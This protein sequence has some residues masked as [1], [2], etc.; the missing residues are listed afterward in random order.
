V[1]VEKREEG[2]SMRAA[3]VQFAPVFGEVELN[4]TRAL[5][6]ISD[7]DADLFVFPELAL[8]GYVFA[9]RAEA[10]ELAQAPDGPELRRVA[11]AAAAK[12]ACVVIGFAER[13]GSSVFNS[14]FFAAPDGA[15]AV[16]RKIHLFDREKTLFDPGDG[17]PLVVEASG[18]RLGLMVCFDWI[19]PEAARTLA[20]AGADVLCHS[21]NLVLPYCQNAVHREPRVRRHGEQDRDRDPCRRVAHLHRAQPDRLAARR[22][23]RAGERGPRGG[24]RGRGGSGGRAGQA[25][26]SRERPLPGQA[27][28]PLQAGL[29]R[30]Q[31]AGMLLAESG[32]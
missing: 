7:Q 21:A 13:A 30:R 27:S 24:H 18:A 25:R 28:Q 16:Y 11:E 8:S 22:R 10:L 15:R 19:F 1:T 32:S 14:S 20:L 6:F 29:V 23:A 31:T 2:T 12:R 9:S 4:L 26:D 17:P 5:R 3:A